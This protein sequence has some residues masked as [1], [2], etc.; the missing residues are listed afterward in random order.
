MN[1]SFHPT[2]RR[3]SKTL[4]VTTT[5]FVKSWVIDFALRLK[6]QSRESSTFQTL[7]NGYPKRLAAAH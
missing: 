5:A 2:R 1:Y 6:W 7:G 3:N 4:R